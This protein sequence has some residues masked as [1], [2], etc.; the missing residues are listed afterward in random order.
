MNLVNGKIMESDECDA[1][2]EDLPARVVHTLEKGKLDSEKVVAACNRF[3]TNLDESAY[4]D[5]MAGLGIDKNL[6]RSYLNEAR[7]MFCQES[8]HYRL[9]VELGEDYGKPVTYTPFFKGYS[10]TE[11]IYP[12]GVLLHIAAGNADGLPAFSVLEGLLTGNIN[13]LKLPAAEGGISVRLLLELIK[14]DPDLAEY[15]YVFDYS[16]N[17][18]VHMEKLISAADAIVVW[19]GREAVTALRKLVPPNIRIIEW[20]HKVSFAYVT[21]EGIT[22]DSL[23]GL[24]TNIADTNQLLCSSLQG[25]F[26]DTSDMQ[27]VY[28]FCKLFLPVL[29]EVLHERQQKIDFGI[30]SQ[31]ALRLYNEELEKIY[32]GSKIF[33]GRNCS[34]IAYPDKALETAIR[35]GNA[36][37]KPLPKAE[38]I[39]ALHLY[40]NYLQTV[41]LVCGESERREI[42]ESLFQAGVVRV[43]RGEHMS[44]AY[45]GAPHDGEYSLRRYT[46]I[47]T[48]ENT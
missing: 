14:A 1:I 7:Q 18:I 41:G 36:W 27:A 6:S 30:R 26:V 45:C 32:R 20:G 19:G 29:E 23:T 13:I 17:D 31:I 2:L 21:R 43:C 15:I 39:E 25:V 9:R 44:M 4:L 22:R 40:K 38:L 16:S 48:H 42:T 8:L 46:K 10:V 3:V 47:V 37:V 35:F 24:A 33:K 34:L 11:N 28:E 12:L 5:T